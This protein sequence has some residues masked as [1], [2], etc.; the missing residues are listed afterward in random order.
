[1]DELPQE[2]VV[3]QHPLSLDVTTISSIETSQEPEYKKRK[4][5]SGKKKMA[6]TSSA[7]SNRKTAQGSRTLKA[8][9]LCRRQ[10]TRCFRSPENPN[11]CL[12]CSFLNKQCSFQTLL[13]GV[14][15]EPTT[16]NSNMMN[17]GMDDGAT[18]RKLDLI[19][20]GINEMLALMRNNDLTNDMINNDARLL[21]DAASTMKNLPNSPGSQQFLE[22]S[23]HGHQAPGLQLHPEYNVYDTIDTNNL[24]IFQS[25]SNS[26]QV[27]PFSIIENELKNPD[28]IP[29]PILNLLNLSAV[30]N[31]PYANDDLISLKILTDL[32]AIDLMNDFRRNYGR[33]ISFPLSIPTAVLIDRVR[34]KSSLLLT[35]CC[36]LSMRYSLN[37]ISPG[38]INNYRRK[39]YTY[40]ALIKQLIKDLNKSLLQITSFQGTRDGSG[41]IE[42]L[43]A[44]VILSI[45]SLSLSSVAR[46]TL[47]DDDEE[48]EYEFLE[49]KSMSLQ[50]LNLDPWYISSVGLTVFISKSTFG[51][52][53][54]KKVGD[55]NSQ[56]NMQ[57]SPFTI[58]YDELDTDE[59]QTLTI[60]RIYNHLSLV[61][62]VSCVFSGRMCVVDEIRLNYCTATLS[63]P[64]ATNFDGRM[65]SEIG[66]LLIA[67]NYVQV[68]LN[69]NTSTYKDCLLSFEAVK[70]E[71]RLWYEQWEYLF[72]QPALQFVELCYDFCNLIIFY[73]FNYQKLVLSTSSSSKRKDKQDQILKDLYKENNIEFI[74]SHCDKNSLVQ[75]LD[76]SY[77]VV[78][79]INFIESD[80]YF[81]YLSDQIHFCFYFSG[82][83]LIKLNKYLITSDQLKLLDEVETNQEDSRSTQEL[84]IT[85]LKNLIEKFGRIG[86]ENK[87]DIISKYKVGLET[88]L[89]GV[90]HN[91]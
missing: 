10:K 24:S 54:K 9:D 13:D 17:S 66:I 27:S 36:C 6:D 68:N 42:L 28:I 31:V 70:E 62:L 55:E 85:D 33:W 77:K 81:A 65:V 91:I 51:N 39:K 15:M 38:D 71:I 1:M 45:Y 72:S 11:S 82:V 60:L 30:K 29:K 56:M 59:Y 8:C 67:Y 73:S 23:I 64:S 40:R 89:E 12:R 86:Q 26:L 22:K 87:D 63:L 61:H 74:L 14:F 44:L 88:M 52:L 35:T 78:K 79:F 58:L 75:M 47:P 7:H 69:V 20:N 90:F 53:F 50:M 4:S 46:A 19:Y 83:C 16:S 80:S 48:E 49:D 41:D 34:F 5:V 32:E 57:Q 21:L 3:N 18:S 76:Y 2:D 25:S 43:Q 84:I 37:S